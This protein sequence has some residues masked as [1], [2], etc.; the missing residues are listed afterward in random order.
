MV[1]EIWFLDFVSYQDPHTHN[2]YWVIP[3]N[4]QECAL[5]T[6]K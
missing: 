6:Y 3:E 4:G 1:D 5:Q 2:S